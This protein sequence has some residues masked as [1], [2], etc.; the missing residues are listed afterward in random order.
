MANIEDLAENYGVNSGIDTEDNQPTIQDMASNYSLNPDMQKQLFTQYGEAR[1][2]AEAQRALL[3]DALE[4][5]LINQQP[6]DKS[7]MYFKLAAA[8]A[9]PSTTRGFGEPLMNVANAMAESR[10]SERKQRNENI[11]KQLSSR[12]AIAELYGEDEKSLGSMLARYHVNQRPSAALQ[13]AENYKMA[14]EPTRQI[15]D[16][17]LSL[18]RNPPQPSLKEVM[19]NG[20]PTFVDASSA[21]GQPPYHPESESA[22]VA[23]LDPNTGEPVL[24]KKSEAFGQKP[25]SSS[26][27]KPFTED[28]SKANTFAQ[29]M[30][31]SHE[32]V[33]KIGDYS[34]MGIKAQ[35][36]TEG[37]PIIGDIVNSQLSSNTQQISNAQRDF[38]TAVNRKESG[39]VISPFE[40][41]EA[42]RLY[43]PQPGDSDEVI[44]QKIGNRVT[45]IKGMREV[46][47]EKHRPKFSEDE[48]S[49]K[50]SDTSNRLEQLRKLHGGN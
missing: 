27:E 30:I 21:I 36:A 49:D 10:A 45:A 8:L 18:T 41:L 44:K 9:A 35:R 3:R 11:A 38:I 39:A 47:P 37:V 2:T 34:P 15:M 23:I 16:K 17:Y 12:Q 32:I 40:I 42:N 26:Q 29:R 28:Q 5:N 14:D 50:N 48:S 31:R 1:K 20:Q 19:V 22:P 7:E 43:F 24:V 6:E 46:I 33:G 13:F 25:A 4:K